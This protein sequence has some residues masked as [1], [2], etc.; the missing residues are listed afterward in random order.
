MNPLHSVLIVDDEPSIRAL[1]ARWVESLGLQSCT[2][3]NAEEAIQAFSTH[4]W[5]LAIIDI[6]MPGRNGLWLAGELRRSHPKTAVVLATANE[7]IVES[8]PAPVVA[9]LLIKPFKRDRF[10]VAV[11]RGREW[12][13]QTVE[14]LDWQARL[15]SEVRSRVVDVQWQLQ[16]GRS[17]GRDESDVLWQL[18]IERMP[19]VAG[20]CDRVG[21]YATS[22]ARE[23]NLEAPTIALI[24]QATRFHDIGKVAIPEAI[25]T[26]PSPHTPEE[27]V[28]MRGHVD[29]GVEILAS[30][31]TLQATVPIVRASHEWFGGTGYPN[32]L[33]GGS[34]P[35]ASRII[36]V[37]D[38]YDAMTHDWSYRSRLDPVEAASELLRCS[39]GQFDPDVVVAFLNIVN[40]H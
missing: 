16:R 25:L 9:D 17:D 31:S 24:E 3:A 23:L 34:I 26:K 7:A 32:G 12:R 5:D 33:A 35:L 19:D 18:S 11:D 37:A 29:A 21:R 10:V 4:Q 6:M 22:I 38:A 15:A 1:L 39:P 28:I 14:E 2:A 40:R 36:A 30:A 8:G 13:R 20:H 27:V